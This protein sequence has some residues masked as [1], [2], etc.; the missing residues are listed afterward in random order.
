MFGVKLDRNSFRHAI[1]KTK[2]LVG[3]AYSTTKN[4]LTDID[5]GIRVAKQI[6]SIVSPVLQ[7]T[8]GDNYHK[9]NKYVMKG[10][11]GY[12]QLRS[13]VMEGDEQATHHYNQVAGDLKK[14][15]IDIG[16][17]K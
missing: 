2:N 5:S 14:A 15:K 6:Y 10:L 11:S 8:L 17:Q 16:L 3:K 12:D 1:G 7:S 9:T 4:V 13:K